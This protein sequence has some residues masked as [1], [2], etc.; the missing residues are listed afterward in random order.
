MKTFS[1]LVLVLISG[2]L[3]PQ[4]SFATS[5]AYSF[6]VWDGYIYVVSEEYVDEVDREIGHVTAYSDMEQYHG[7]FSNAYRE[8]TKYF[9]IEG[10]RKEEAI[11]VQEEDGRFI[12]ADRESEYLR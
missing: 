2:I 10:V 3:L 8:G 5:W 11:A 7:N 6:V 4:P 12:K 1:L 9:S